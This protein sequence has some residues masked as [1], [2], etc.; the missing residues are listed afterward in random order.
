MVSQYRARRKST[1][2]MAEGK[3]HLTPLC[4]ALAHLFSAVM[5][6]LCL[7]SASPATQQLKLAAGGHVLCNLLVH[8]GLDCPL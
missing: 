7:M 5:S 2:L 4:T 3:R 8:L 1:D 6:F